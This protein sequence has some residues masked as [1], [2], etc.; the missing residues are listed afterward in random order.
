MDVT[1][2]ISKWSVVKDFPKQEAKTVVE[3]LMHN[4]SARHC[5]LLELRS[6]QGRYFESYIWKK[7]MTILGNKKI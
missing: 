4:V 1:D 6:D 3:D 2:Y 5:I 7:M